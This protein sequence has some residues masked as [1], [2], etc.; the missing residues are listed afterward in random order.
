[1]PPVTRVPRNFYLDPDLDALLSNRATAEGIT[2][3]ELVNRLLR[4]GLGRCVV[5][6]LKPGPHTF[7]P[8][9]FGWC[10]DC[11]YSEHEVLKHGEPNKPVTPK[12]LTQE[13]RDALALLKNPCERDRW[14]VR[15]GEPRIVC[16]EEAT[17]KTPVGALYCEE[18]ALEYNADVLQHLDKFP[19]SKLRRFLAE[20][21]M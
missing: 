6:H 4:E 18:H 1:M 16:D 17:Y 9:A 8:S 13:V 11:G 3:G 10:A 12:P 5:D 2:K 15:Y 19:E 7:R 14:P 21:W 20:P